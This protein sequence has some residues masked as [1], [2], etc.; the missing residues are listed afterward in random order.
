MENAERFDPPRAIPSAKKLGENLHSLTSFV[1]LPAIPPNFLRPLRLCVKSALRSSQVLMETQ[2]RKDRKEMLIRHWRLKH[3]R[4][5]WAPSDG[6]PKCT[7][8]R[9]P[10]PR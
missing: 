8:H 7:A 2:R 3:S 10:R 1:R 5:A 9:R 6:S 4:R